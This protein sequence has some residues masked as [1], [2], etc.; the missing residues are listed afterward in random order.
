VTWEPYEV[1]DFSPK[2]LDN[3][4]YM[5][6]LGAMLDERQLIVIREQHE[7]SVDEHLEFTSRL[8][9]I[10]PSLP[11]DTSHELS[12]NVQVM[13][14]RPPEEDPVQNKRMSSSFYWH[15]DRSFLPN[16]PAITTL[17]AQALP[18]SGGETLFANMVDALDVARNM[19]IT[20]LEHLAIHSYAAYFECLQSEFYTPKKVDQARQLFPDAQHPLVRSHPRTEKQA[21]NLSEL[22]LTHLADLPG[23]ASRRL[24]DVLYRISTADHN[25]YIHSWHEGDLLVWGNFGVMHKGMPSSGYRMLRRT[26]AGILEN[27]QIASRIKRPHIHGCHMRSS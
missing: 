27:L 3:S 22:C 11:V 6:W 1:F 15:T 23:P 16:P 26:V 13:V 7:L 4:D 20:D 14:R 25:V 9:T 19:G 5:A 8:G 12:A 10:A 17:W 18:Y 21:L 2:L 24:L